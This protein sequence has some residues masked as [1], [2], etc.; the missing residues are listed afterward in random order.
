MLIPVCTLPSDS[1]SLFSHKQSKVNW[2][3]VKKQTKTKQK[4]PPHR[5][6]QA[7]PVLLV[8]CLIVFNFSPQKAWEPVH[9]FLT[10][11]AWVRWLEKQMRFSSLTP[12]LLIQARKCLTFPSNMLLTHCGHTGY[13]TKGALLGDRP[14]GSSQKYLKTHLVL[15]IDPHLDP[16]SLLVPLSFNESH[17][18]VKYKPAD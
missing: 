17:P 14:K 15:S 16:I 6:L 2:S 1:L 10:C 7:V 5:P 11:F 13:Q 8:N 4:P 3:L 12:R 18:K 9:Y